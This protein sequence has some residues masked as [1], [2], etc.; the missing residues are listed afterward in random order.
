MVEG[1]IDLQGPARR[2]R[3]AR[4]AESGAPTG[5]QVM[6]GPGVAAVP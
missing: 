3:P 4:R 1:A 2:A 6:S 5:F